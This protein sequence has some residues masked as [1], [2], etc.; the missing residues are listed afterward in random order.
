MAIITHFQKVTIQQGE[1]EEE[2]I[3]FFLPP[4][5]IQD[6]FEEKLKIFF[7]KHLLLS[8]YSQRVKTSLFNFIE[9]ADCLFACSKR[10]G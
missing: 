4:P 5:A 7:L 9:P 6:V 2:K 3:S 10:M 1:E 8:S